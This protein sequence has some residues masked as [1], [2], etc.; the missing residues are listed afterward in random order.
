MLEGW[1]A[2]SRLY[3][4]AKL[5]MDLMSQMH[6]QPAG[7]HFGVDKTH[8]QI[9]EYYTW[10]GSHKDVKAFVQR[11]SVCAQTKHSTCQPAGSPTPLT[12]AKVPWQDISVDLVIDLPDNSS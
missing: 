12:L 7:G 6:D 3:I 5:R 2:R 9:L 10:P 11:C 4:S 8:K 1:K